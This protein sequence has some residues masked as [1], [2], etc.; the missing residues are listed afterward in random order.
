M[1]SL[2]DS[3]S[4][5]IRSTFTLQMLVYI[6]RHC[7]HWACCPITKANFSTALAGFAWI[8]HLI[9][10]PDRKLVLCQVDDD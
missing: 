9:A 6:L 5:G 2:Y 8:A 3:L 10:N 7:W 1:T 4:E